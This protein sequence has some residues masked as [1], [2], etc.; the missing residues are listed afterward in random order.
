MGRGLPVRPGSPGCPCEAD[1]N[2]GP[3][4]RRGRRDVRVQRTRV[5]GCRS[6]WGGKSLHARE[7]TD[8]SCVGE[9]DETSEVARASV[10]DPAGQR[11][12]PPWSG[13]D[14]LFSSQV[15]QWL[16]TLGAAA[17]VG[18]SSHKTHER[19]IRYAAW[20][21]RRVS[22]PAGQ[23]HRRPCD[24]GGLVL[25]RRRGMSPYVP[26]RARTFHPGVTAV[27]EACPF[28]ADRP[29]DLQ[30]GTCPSRTDS[31]LSLQASC[32]LRWVS[33]SEGHTCGPRFR[34]G[35]HHVSVSAGPSTGLPD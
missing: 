3:P 34:C 24:H 4:I 35:L 2:R 10:S 1:T 7:H 31:L 23:H 27:R 18:G 12:S 29:L 8:S 5:R 15:F 26:V 13:R 11:C 25:L 16:T 20:P 32:G 33:V 22:F 17:S 9:V 6:G 30:L 21:R 19:K 14:S 28:Q